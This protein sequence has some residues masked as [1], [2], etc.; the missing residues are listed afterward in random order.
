[1][2]RLNLTQYV[3]KGELVGPILDLAALADKGGFGADVRAKAARL[4]AASDLPD[5]TSIQLAVRSGSKPVYDATSWGDWAPC[6]AAGEAKGDL[7]RFVQ[8]RAVLATTKPKTTPALRGIEL[9]AE[10]QT[11]R[12]AWAADVKLL[13]SHNEEIRY[14][15]MPFEYEK[16]DEPALVELRTKYK[17]DEVVAGSH[18]EIEKMLKLRN[19]VSAQWKYDPPIPYYPAWDAREILQLR[20]GFCVQYAITTMQCALSL[21]MQARFVFGHFPNTRLKGKYTCGHEVTEIWSN[22]QDKWVMIDGHRNESFVNKKTGLIASMLELH[23]DQLN[24]YFPNG[25]DGQG[26]AFDDERPSDGL[27]G[28][29]AAEPTPRPEKPVPELKWGWVQWVPRNNFYAHRFPEPVLQ[30]LT[31]SWTGYWNWE[32]SRTPRQWRF[33][34]FTG[35]RSDIEWT[36]DQVRWA[37]APGEAPGA[38]RIAMG[39]VTPDFDTFLVSLDG[40]EWRPS[41][42]AFAWTLHRGKNRIDMRVR[43]RAGILGRASWIEVEWP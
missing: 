7:R 10:V 24:S 19:W 27:L 3:A 13:G 36:L 28:W 1:M 41:T 31:W 43:T 12:P 22:E 15:S 32:D 21:G 18:T 42:D 6:D 16:F 4:R 37:A 39:T 14:T 35:R 5:G 33:G 11:Q 29:Y 38:V 8:W 2:V 26:A 34:E 20:K 30:G 9:Q 25:F 17:L 23:E 40:G